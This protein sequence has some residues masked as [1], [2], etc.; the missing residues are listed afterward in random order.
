MLATNV[1]LERIAGLM[2]KEAAA[3]PKGLEKVVR[4]SLDQLKKVRASTT[5]K[6]RPGRTSSFVRSAAASEKGG[7]LPRRYA[8]TNPLAE[9]RR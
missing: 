2:R 5:R 4:G 3:V 9:R 7:A 8:L 6:S 1:D